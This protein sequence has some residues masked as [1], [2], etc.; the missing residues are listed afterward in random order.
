MPP[1]AAEIV[2]RLDIAQ[3]QDEP[4]LVSSLA[5]LQNTPDEARRMAI[6]ALA[7]TSLAPGDY[8]VRATLRINGRDEGRVLR[9]LRKVRE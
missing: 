1:R 2:V 5:H 6:A 8:I 9:T 4:A 7:L 3:T